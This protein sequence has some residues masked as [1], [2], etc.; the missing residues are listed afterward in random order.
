MCAET[1]MGPGRV[2]KPG[3]IAIA[4]LL[5]LSSH[6]TAIPTPTDIET[7]RRAFDSARHAL[8]NDD[9]ASF[10][11]LDPLLVSYPLYP[12]L[13]YEYLRGRL[14]SA[15]PG[16][17]EQFFSAYSDTPVAGQLRRAWLARLAR[18]ERWEEY[19]AGYTAQSNEELHCHYLNALVQTGHLDRAWQEIDGAWL[20]PI[21]Q[22]D[23]CDAPF[24]AWR[25]AGRMTRDKVLA[26]IDLSLEKGERGLVSYLAGFLP[27]NDQP[28]IARWQRIHRSPA[29]ELKHLA[30]QSDPFWSAKLFSYGIRRLS[31]QDGDLAL[32]LWQQQER[33]G[34]TADQV[35]NTERTLALNLARQRHPQGAPLLSSVMERGAS[36]PE[37]RQW[38]VRAALWQQDW[39]A[40]L[41]A[42]EALPSDEQGMEEWQYWR[43][44]ALESLGL[45]REAK[46][47]YELAAGKRSFYAFLAA[48]RA[49]VV[50][51]IESIPLNV[52]EQGLEEFQ[53]RPAMLRIRELIALGMQVEARREWRDAVASMDSDNLQAAAKLAH[54]WGWHD[55]A[56][57]VLGRS[58]HHSDLEVR[59]PT[60]YLE[61]IH[62]A[63]ESRGID[64]AFVF[65]VVRQE[66][67]FGAEA[68]S[69]V[70]ALGL[71]QLMPATAR[72]TARRIKQP[73]P[74]RADLLIPAKNIRLGT[75]YLA[76]LLDRYEGNRFFT[77]AAY[78]AGPHRVSRWQPEADPV[79]ADIWVANITFKE[80][81]E[82]VERILTYTAV[83]EWRLGREITPISNWLPDVPPRIIREAR[84]G[85][86]VLTASQT[87]RG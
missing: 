32:R 38:R 37:V 76:S 22:P 65:A 20:S 48:S 86:K 58:D 25:K 21:S 12:Y 51:R 87:P 46:V 45:E 36:D 16:E 19:L 74:S 70:G 60:P 42:L 72:Q 71:M 64:P 52:S 41:A 66:S 84:E 62:K 27:K 30:L 6:A 40:V 67:A 50:P 75:A 73:A 79:P 53:Q 39:K 31:G 33:Y 83:Y 18:E 49:G 28:W 43:A 34:L 80:T 23:E 2:H 59:F 63:A 29:A 7:Q 17:M 14:G 81:R 54:Q 35:L 57:I 47:Y 61:E 85:K 15:T 68:K 3:M 69:P 5:L 55:Q 9:L 44:R 11:R 26:R 56:I 82:Y 1:V 13:R 8:R 4:S 24:A 78:N 77:L 10:R